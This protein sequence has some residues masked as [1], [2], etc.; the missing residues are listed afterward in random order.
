[1]QLHLLS[2]GTAA[3]ELGDITKLK[4]SLAEQLAVALQHIGF[5]EPDI[6]P[7]ENPR[8]DAIVYVEAGKNALTPASQTIMITIE[9]DDRVRIQIPSDISRSGKKNLA[10]ILNIDDFFITGSV[11]EA[12]A[13]LKDIKG[14]ADQLMADQGLRGSLS[15]GHIG[16]SEEPVADYMIGQF[17]INSIKPAGWLGPNLESFLNDRIPDLIVL[18]TETY[19]NPF[20]RTGWSSD[21]TVTWAHRDTIN[22]KQLKQQLITLFGPEDVF[23]F[24]ATKFKLLGM[25]STVEEFLGIFDADYGRVDRLTAKINK[26][27]DKFEAGIAS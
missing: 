22:P 27:A 24:A 23:D 4:N 26:M 2:E 7:A 19:N 25:A 20:P 17:K 8:D 13:R 6:R 3:S 11:G 10:D 9:D 16:E 12:I 21:S 5:R 18:E 14:K 1:M 15:T